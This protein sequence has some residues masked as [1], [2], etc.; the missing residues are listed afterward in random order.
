MNIDTPDNIANSLSHYIQLTGNPES[1]NILYGLYDKVTVDDVVRVAKQYFVHEGL[2][3]A[4]ISE[5]ELG[6]V[7]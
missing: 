4:T 7:K 3:I 2:T 6:G 5:L 1:L